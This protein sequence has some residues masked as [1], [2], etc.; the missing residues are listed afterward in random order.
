MTVV[1]SRFLDHKCTLKWCTSADSELG[2]KLL[3][4]TTLKGALEWPLVGMKAP[5]VILQR[6]NASEAAIAETGTG[7]WGGW[8]CGSGDDAVDG[9]DGRMIYCRLCSCICVCGMRDY[10]ERMMEKMV[11]VGG[12][13]GW[14]E[15]ER[16]RVEHNAEPIIHLYW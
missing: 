7:L 1:Q 8:G 11:V 14:R 9:R 12:G 3:A 2:G 15:R 13:G 6:I 16:S 4:I 5:N 10:Y